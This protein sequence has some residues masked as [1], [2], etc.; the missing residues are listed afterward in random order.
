MERDSSCSGNFR[1]LLT[2][3][4]L[5]CFYRVGIFHIISVSFLPRNTLCYLISLQLFP[6]VISVYLTEHPVGTFFL[7]EAG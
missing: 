1:G 6:A 5:G 2:L 3:E 7:E 4:R